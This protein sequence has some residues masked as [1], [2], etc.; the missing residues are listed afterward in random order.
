MFNI[1]KIIVNLIYE[2]SVALAFAN[3]SSEE[4]TGLVLSFLNLFLITGMGA[5]QFRVKRK[6]F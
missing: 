4:S 5:A 2:P 3:V 6:F 1:I